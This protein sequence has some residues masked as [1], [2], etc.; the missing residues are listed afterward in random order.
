MIL[1][2]NSIIFNRMEFE[3]FLINMYIGIIV[4]RLLI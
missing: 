4:F 1:K 2:F 3:I